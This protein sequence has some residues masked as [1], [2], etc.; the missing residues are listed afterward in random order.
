MANYYALAD[1]VKAKLNGLTYMAHASLLKTLANKHQTKMKEIILK[2]KQGK[3]YVYRYR[4]KGEEKEI[5]FFKLKDLTP[6]PRTWKEI[7]LRPSTYGYGR[8]TEILQRMA[9]QICE[10]CGR[11]DGYFEVHHVRK[12]SDIK[13]GKEEWQKLMIARRRKT[14][15]LCVECHDLL[16]AGRL[17]S[18]R[19]SMKER[20]ESCQEAIT[21]LSS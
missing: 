4:V 15:V 8:E 5:R 10:Y 2:L 9:A 11:E 13:G 19:R 17:P 18:W 14:M 3:D 20:S 21:R 12:L 7:D 1:D 6:Q 16:H